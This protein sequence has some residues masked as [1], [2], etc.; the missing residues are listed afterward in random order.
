MSE[1]TDLREQVAI[2]LPDGSERSFPAGVTGLE[3]ATSIGRKLAQDALGI[4]VDGRLQ[5]LAT[6]ISADAGVAIVTFDSPEGRE[7]FWHSSSHLMAQA[8]E[9]LF[10]GAKF[11]AGPAVEQGFYYDV[12]YP[13]RFNEEDLR[14]IEARMLEIAGRDE[15]IVREEMPRL[16]AI[17]YFRESRKDPYKVEI[18][19]ETLKEVET[20]SVYR[21]GGFADLCTGPHLPNT[22]KVTP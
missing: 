4:K 22:G 1:T 2:T 5:D 9:E 8:I 6:P 11:G 20:V 13:E 16:Q 12:S 18:L 19:E 7:L 3:I 10:P 21:Q 15:A 14:A 17:G